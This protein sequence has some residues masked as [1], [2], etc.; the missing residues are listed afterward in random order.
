MDSN[1]TDKEGIIIQITCVLQGQD[2]ILVPGFLSGLKRAHE[3]YGEEKWAELMHTA[4]DVAKEYTV[5]SSLGKCMTS[6]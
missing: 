2:E 1:F 6:F 3:D 5:T 4:A